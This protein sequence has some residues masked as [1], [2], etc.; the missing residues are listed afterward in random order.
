M[1]DV[2]LGLAPLLA[3]HYNGLPQVIGVGSEREIFRGRR[4]ALEPQASGSD[5]KRACLWQISRSQVHVINLYNLHVRIGDLFTTFRDS[6]STCANYPVPN[7]YPDLWPE[8]EVREMAVIQ[9]TCEALV[10]P[11]ETGR[12]SAVVGAFLV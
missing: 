1:L 12:R 8:Q 10:G 7:P 3:H 9:G 4:S 5:E 11:L 6:Q 2:V